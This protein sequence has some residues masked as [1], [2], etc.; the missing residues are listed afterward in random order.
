MSEEKEVLKIVVTRLESA[1]IAYMA[2]GSIA[3]NFYTVPRMTRDIDFVVELTENDVDRFCSLFEK[4]FYIDKHA[5]QQAI[6]Q[7]GMFNIIH[8]GSIVKVDFIPRKDSEYRRLEFS[9]RQMISF[10]GVNV[11]ITAPEDL[12]LSKLY[13][14]KDSHSE[15]QLRDAR[16]LVQTVPNL[17]TAYLAEW[18]VKLNLEDIYKEVVQWMI[19]P[20]K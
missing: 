13:W 14:T 19:P 9:R 7:K 8:Q 3:A 10:E 5:V 18:V 11:A 20:K 4:D 15:M 2:T 17:D 6:R 1:H 16:N 12:I